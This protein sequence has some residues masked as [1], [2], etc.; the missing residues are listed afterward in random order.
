MFRVTST[1][2]DD[3]QEGDAGLFLPR[4]AL[5]TRL[6]VQFGAGP[7]VSDSILTDRDL[8]EAM[9]LELKLPRP[10]LVRRQ[11]NRDRFSAAISEARSQLLSYREWFRDSENRQR[12]EPRL[13]MQIYEARLAVIVGRSR[14]FLDEVDRQRLRASAADIEV[15]TYDDILEHAKR[16]LVKLRLEPTRARASSP[17]ELRA[18]ASPSPLE[19]GKGIE[20][21]WG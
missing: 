19:G 21:M 6:S 3:V 4:R 15:V 14:E 5:L 8:E 17:D 7:F 18:G 10:E 11:R 9:V 2:D 20:G 1:L 16:L 12:L 13:G